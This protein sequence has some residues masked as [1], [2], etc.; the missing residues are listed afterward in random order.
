[1][2]K[3]IQLLI[4]MSGQ[5]NRYRE[6]GYTQP[7]P[8]IPVNGV[9]MISRLLENFPESWKTVFVMAEN[10]RNTELPAVLSKERPQAKQ[11][12][13][14]KHTQGPSFA[15]LKGL[16]V[17]DPDAPVLLSYC[18]YA[19]VWDSARFA[20]FVEESQCEACVISY[21]GYH[22]HYRSSLQYAYSRLEGERVVE[23]KEKG[24]FTSNRENEFASSGGYYFKSGKLLKEAIEFQIAQNLQLNGEFY[25]SLT[26][27]A[28]LRKNPKSHVRVFEIPGFFQWGTPEDLQIFEYWERSFQAYNRIVGLE[29]P[30]VAQVLMPM[31]GLGSRFSKVTSMP[32]PFIPV[33]DLS[34]YQ[35]ALRTL[36][37]SQKTV[38]VS[39]ESVKSYLNTESVIVKLL[40]ETPQGQ[41]LSTEAGLSHLD[42]TAEVIVS[43]CD[44]G[45]VLDPKIWK[46]FHRN[47][48]CE[49]AIFTIRGYPGAKNHPNAYAYVVSQKRGYFPEVEKVSVKVPVS[50]DPS[51][52]SLLVGTFWFQSGEV[53]ERGISSL[54]KSEIQ[55]NGELYLDSIFEILIQ[56]GMKVREI[57]LSG[58]LCWGDPESLAEALYWEEIFCGYKIENRSQFPGVK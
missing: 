23:V 47:P 40:K 58:Y 9:P 56:E 13:I 5:G 27:E 33:G 7:K 35:R 50:K 30:Q 1:M 51:N 34:M 16:E 14:E 31:A 39:L 12:F 10:H 43:S 48:D 25:S 3:P 6:A 37:V 19:M 22:A 20:R 28:L 53:L 24:S 46:E 55:V 36:P 49:A 15:A 41:A 21:R 52:D 38:L 11:I 45:I 17:L 26:V 8:L 29:P 57:P 54:K 44:H 4:P 18:D 42:K 2:T 32:K